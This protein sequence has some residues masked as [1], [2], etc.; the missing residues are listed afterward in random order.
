MFEGDFADTCANKFLLEL[1]GGERT[2]QACA[3]G[4]RGPHRHERK[5]DVI[6]NYWSVINNY[7]QHFTDL[8][9]TP[10]PLVSKI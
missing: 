3:D 1:M 8:P 6:N 9:P 5:F 2:R 4:E 7:R 10:Q